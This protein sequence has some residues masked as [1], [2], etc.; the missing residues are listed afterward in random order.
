MIFR[1]FGA[2][3]VFLLAFGGVLEYSYQV[4]YELKP[5]SNYLAIALIFMALPLYVLVLGFVTLVK[6]FQPALLAVFSGLAG[7]YCLALIKPDPM[8]EVLI[9]PPVPFSISTNGDI[10]AL[11]AAVCFAI[12]A[13][14]MF[15]SFY[16]GFISFTLPEEPIEE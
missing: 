6:P 10:I 8:R 14:Q 13:R 16:D 11:I 4:I 12:T 3:V 7:V 2:L 15:V 5:T 9:P 1:L